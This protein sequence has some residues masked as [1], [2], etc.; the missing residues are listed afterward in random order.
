MVGR[1][2]RG[3][4]CAVP[5]SPSASPSLRAPAETAPSQ[6]QPEQRCGE[7]NV[8]KSSECWH[9]PG[10]LLQKHRGVIIIRHSHYCTKNLVN[11]RNFHNAKYFP[12]DGEIIISSSHYSVLYFL[13][14]CL[15]QPLQRV[16]LA[17]HV[18]ISGALCLDHSA[19]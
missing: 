7:N 6:L 4:E 15:Y 2:H 5:A 18:F 13:Y 3:Y 10:G 16:V 17:V 11:R 1:P 8:E 12:T 14:V 9:F 19:P